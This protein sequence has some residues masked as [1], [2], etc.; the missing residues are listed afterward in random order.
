MR[1]IKIL[2]DG[3]QNFLKFDMVSCKYEHVAVYSLQS[4]CHYWLQL[5]VQ[6]DSG[7]AVVEYEDASSA[8]NTQLQVNGYMLNGHAIRVTYCIPGQPATDVY[9]RLIQPTVGSIILSFF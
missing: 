6:K 1:I 9:M 4:T 3:L 7:F 8:E 2:V 5:G